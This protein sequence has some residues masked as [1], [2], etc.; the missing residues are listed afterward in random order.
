MEG[1]GCDAF[2]LHTSTDDPVETATVWN[3]DLPT[4]PRSTPRRSTAGSRTTASLIE[5]LGYACLCFAS[6]VTARRA[7]WKRSSCRAR[8]SVQRGDTCGRCSR[9]TTPV[10]A[11]LGELALDRRLRVVDDAVVTQETRFADGSWRAEDLTLRLESG[12]PFSAE[13]DPPTTARMIRALDGSRTLREALAAAV[14]SD[15]EQGTGLALA[16][17]M[18][19][20][21]FELC[22]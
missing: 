4:G 22:V 2:L 14:E 7:G 15:A 8:R 6:G 9:R 12:L 16:R 5:Q 10:G 3:R 18:L 21:A 17:R 1:S 13:L 20:I 11:R 19:E